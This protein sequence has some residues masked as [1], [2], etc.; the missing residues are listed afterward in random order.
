VSEGKGK[1]LVVRG[2][3]I[4]DFVLTLPV[5]AALRG[6]FPGVRLEL[7]CYARVAPLATTAGL[8]DHSESIDARPMA[9]FFARNGPLPARLAAYFGGF[10][11]IIS[12]LFDPDRIFQTNVARC[13]KAQFLVGPHRPDE[14][15]PL[16]AT[17][18]FLR[19]LARLAIFD[20]DPVP[21]LD[22][23][24][25]A[26]DGPHVNL[27][28]S[29]GSNAQA[30][31]S[32]QTDRWLALHPG[33]GSERKNWPEERWTALLRRLS[34]ETQLGFLLLGGEAEGERLARLAAVLPPGR[35]RIADSLPLAEVGALL[36]QCRGYLGHDSGISH[37]AAAVGVRGL[38]LWGETRPEVW[39]PRSERVRI[40]SSP[41]CLGDLAVEDVLT[42]VRQMLE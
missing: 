15:G 33:S 26:G 8:V 19:P 27:E 31:P 17:D 13:S 14:D 39:R 42:G 22:L 24:L 20:A 34:A 9:S 38:I 5:L 16:H 7:M 35:S 1:I 25:V 3:A 30:G 28:P 6:Q 21:R 32:T 11:L 4:G 41:A 12:Y 36:Q 29:L 23:P 10:N 2:G 37:L 40:L 18:A